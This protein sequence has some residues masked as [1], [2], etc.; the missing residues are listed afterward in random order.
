MQTFNFIFE[1]LVCS[2][3]VCV[4]SFEDLVCSSF[5]FRE[6]D[7][8]FVAVCDDWGRMGDEGMLQFYFRTVIFF[9]F[10]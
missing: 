8:I 4:F 10:Q 7:D 1:D 5:L 2:L 6:I 9:F 3:N